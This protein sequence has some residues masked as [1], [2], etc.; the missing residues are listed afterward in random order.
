MSLKGIC[1]WAEAL[2]SGDGGKRQNPPGNQNINADMVD[3]MH[4][5]DLKADWEAYADSVGGS[6]GSSGTAGGDLSGTYPDPTVAKIQG[7]PVSTTD[8]TDGQVLAYING[9]YTPMDA[10]TLSFIGTADLTY[11][12]GTY[13]WQVPIGLKKIKVLVIGAGGGGGAAF[14]RGGG[15]GGVAVHN[16]YT[17]SGGQTLYI[18][19]GYGGD[20]SYPPEG[21]LNGGNGG[22]SSISGSGSSAI[23]AYGGGGGG[24][25]TSGTG[26]GGTGGSFSVP[27]GG[28]GYV[29]GAGGESSAAAP[30]GSGA[31]GGGGGYNTTAKAANP[32][33][34]GFYAGGGGAGGVM[35]PYT[36]GPGGASGPYGEDGGVGAGDTYSGFFSGGT[37]GKGGGGGGASNSGHSSGGWGSSWYGGSGGGGRVIIRIDPTKPDFEQL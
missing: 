24:S 30:G 37:G 34:D 9:E 4:Y 19:V 27:S 31:T 11:G 12:P 7:I 25:G 18:E 32:G 33:G 21:T 1:D 29:G 23:F 17:V 16:S 35:Y 2:A 20:G 3:G 26:G 36:Q 8:P 6:S 13:T 22:L 28:F 15:G 10:G 14:C 5:T